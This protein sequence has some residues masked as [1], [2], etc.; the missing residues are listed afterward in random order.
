ADVQRYLSDEPVQACPPSAW[1]RIRKFARRHVAAVTIVALCL[2]FLVMLAGTIGWFGRD[3]AA[4][5]Q[6][7]EEAVNQALK[8][9]QD[10][11]EKGKV[12][13]A[14]SAARRAEGIAL[15]GPTSARLRQQ[16][17]TRLADLKLLEKLEN[18]RLEMTWGKDRN[19]DFERADAL[20]GAT[21]H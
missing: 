2:F 8:E 16:V 10:W 3:R 21:F 6:L 20:Y 12:P 15:G 17:Q 1:Y 5:Q 18:I 14:L 4:R 7:V 11:Q 13:E 19:L 9:S